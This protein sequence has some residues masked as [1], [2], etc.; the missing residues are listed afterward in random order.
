MQERL[1]NQGLDTGVPDGIIGNQSR[2][3]IRAFQRTRGL[4]E[5]G[6]PS[7]QL[8]ELLRQDAVERTE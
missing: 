8:L 2:A 1:Q 4:P 7:V 3:A 5:D 6:Y